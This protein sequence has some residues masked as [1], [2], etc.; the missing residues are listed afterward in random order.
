MIERKKSIN[1]RAVTARPIAASIEDEQSQ[2]PEHLIRLPGDGWAMWRCS[3]L[4][5]AGFPAADVLMLSA[6]DC[7]KA[8]DSLLQAEAETRS[9]RDKTIETVNKALD[10]LRSNSM[11]DDRAIRDP[12]VKTLRLL[13]MGMLPAFPG[14]GSYVEM[15]VDALAAASA[16]VGPALHSYQQS[17]K[18]AVADAS[19]K[20][21]ELVFA[22]RFREAVLWQN[23]HAYHTA[24]PSLLN[25]TGGPNVRDSKQR[26]Y[27]ELFASY[28][29][30]YCVKNDTTGF[31]GPVGWARWVSES[32]A[33]V[34]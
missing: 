25:K 19:D 31:F 32:E 1:W 29:Q 33:F 3:G 21:K 24:V 14:V 28:L 18:A 15:A 2:L 34:V 4:R 12:L 20:I 23:R 9:A 6:P 22:D 17:Y 5:G 10:T 16:R 11:W 8:A 7:A 13:K 27:E 26:Q 30:R